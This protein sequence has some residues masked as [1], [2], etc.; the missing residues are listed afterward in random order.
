VLVPAARAGYGFPADVRLAGFW[1]GD[2]K[3]RGG[4]RGLG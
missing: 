3:G 2:W 4:Q 1:T